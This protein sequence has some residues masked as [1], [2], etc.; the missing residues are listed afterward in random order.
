MPGKPPPSCDCDIIIAGGGLASGLIA[1]ALAKKQPHL[2]VRIVESGARLGGNHLWSFFSQDVMPEHRWLVEPLISY[3]WDDYDIAFP[4]HART[5]AMAYHSIES[6]QF[7]SVV[8][9]RSPLAGW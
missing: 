3:R 7:D 4:A 6:T 2:D 5:L 8:R 9:A 1:L